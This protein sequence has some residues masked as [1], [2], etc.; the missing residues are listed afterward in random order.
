MS[1]SVQIKKF[2]E[3]NGIL[4]L[5]KNMEGDK[6]SF[7]LMSLYLNDI[8][9]P[10]NNR[11]TITEQNMMA[12]II[13]YSIEKGVVRDKEQYDSLVD[14]LIKKKA[15]NNKAIFNTNKT[16][17]VNKGYLEKRTGR[18]TVIVPDKVLKAFSIGNINV[19]LSK[20]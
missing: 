13:D 17:L 1:K 2:C 4:C 18:N 12:H 10:I 6:I 8:T 11:L 3:E 9:K 20:H 15:V 19:F 14:Y 5:A 16:N 7:Y